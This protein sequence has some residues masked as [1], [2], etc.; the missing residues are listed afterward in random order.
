MD[1]FT[2]TISFV[3]VTCLRCYPFTDKPTPSCM[4]CLKRQGVPA[5]AW[6]T[7]LNCDAP[8][9]L[10]HPRRV[11]PETQRSGL[12]A[13][14]SEAWRRAGRPLAPQLS[15]LPL[16]LPQTPLPSVT[17]AGTFLPNRFESAT[18]QQQASGKTPVTRKK[19]FGI[20]CFNWEKA[21][22][23]QHFTLVPLI[24]LPL[25]LWHLNPHPRW[26]RAL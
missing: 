26:A 6:S 16:V 5:T 24:S 10:R 3:V 8:T 7:F 11:E 15:L 18:C 23:T 25:A 22:L 12:P 21:K 19:V 1:C 17:R 20:Y 9:Q 4:P 14:R 2:Q 13:A